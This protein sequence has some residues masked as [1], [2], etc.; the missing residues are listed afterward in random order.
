MAFKDKLW[1]IGL[2]GAILA[3]VGA[4][5]P[6]IGFSTTIMI[7]TINVFVWLFGFAIMDIGPYSM[8]GF[9]VDP[10]LMTMFILLLAGAVLALI[11]SFLAKKREDKKVMG[12]I[13]I[14]AGA[15]I[16]VAMF[17]PLIQ[18]AVL[19]G[20]YVPLGLMPLHVGFYLPLIGG[21]LAIVAGIGAVA[22]K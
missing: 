15:L 18:I 22:M 14:I 17:I 13:W 11:I 12:I 2:I 6:Y 3:L 21:I 1:L 16:L 5:L 8:G 4:F 10:M 20:P 9:V 19:A 7:Y